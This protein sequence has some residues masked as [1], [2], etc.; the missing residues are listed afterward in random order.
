[1]PRPT[2]HRKDLSA[3]WRNIHRLWKLPFEEKLAVTISTLEEI[4]SKHSNPVVCWSGG[5]DSTVA[6]HLILS[7]HPNIPIIFTKTDVDFL[8]TY[9]YI[10]MLAA[11]WRLNLH[12]KEPDQTFWDIGAKYGWPIFGKSVASN[13]ERARRTG[14]IRPQ[15]SQIE[16]ELIE[17]NIRISTKCSEKLHEKASKNLESSL[18]CDLKILG[19]RAEESRARVRLW[20]DHGDYYYIKRYYKRNHGIWKFSPISIWTKN[21]IYKYFLL[22][23]LPTCELYDLGYPRNGCWSCAMA[24]RNGQLTR[25]K[26][27]HPHLFKILIYDS[28]MGIDLLKAKAFCESNKLNKKYQIQLPVF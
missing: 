3:G 25:L 24:I 22:H 17:S 9:N 13:V 14:N 5:K 28:P 26:T 2:N 16:K 12:I 27:H 8:E 19:I 18:K 1:M 6:L 15:L 10:D 4:I 23:D 11:K 21:D 7:T 20:V